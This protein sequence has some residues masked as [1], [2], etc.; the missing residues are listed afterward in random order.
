MTEPQIAVALD[1]SPRQVQRYLARARAAGMNTAKGEPREPGAPPIPTHDLT[2]NEQELLRRQ[3]AAKVG[4]FAPKPE[5]DPNLGRIVAVLTLDGDG[6]FSNDRVP[7][8]QDHPADLGLPVAKRRRV[9]KHGEGRI[10]ATE[11][12]PEER[13][14]AIRNAAGLPD[15]GDSPG[16]PRSQLAHPAISQFV[17]GNGPPDAHLAAGFEYEPD[18]WFRPPT[19]LPEGATHKATVFE[20]GTV[21]VESL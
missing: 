18:E 21:A 12:G 1:K 15:R 9:L 19:I 2:P 7:E 14:N 16:I 17:C 11:S 8:L 5:H 10:S 4:P 6:R 20:D 3:H 13:Q